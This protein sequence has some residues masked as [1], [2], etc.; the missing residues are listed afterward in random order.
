MNVFLKIL[1]SMWTSFI[2]EWVILYL[3]WPVESFT[4]GILKLA[5]HFFP[6]IINNLICIM[7]FSLKTKHLYVF[8]SVFIEQYKL[9]GCAEIQEYHVKN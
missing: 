2:E 5:E 9:Y 6:H 4:D 8:D 7:F 1:L 3:N